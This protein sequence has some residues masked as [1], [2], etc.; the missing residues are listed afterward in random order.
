[1]GDADFIPVFQASGI[2][3]RRITW[4]SARRTRS[5][6]SCHRSDLQPLAGKNERPDIWS[7]L[8]TQ[9]TPEN[10][11]CHRS[12]SYPNSRRRAVTRSVAVEGGGVL[13]MNGARLCAK[14][15]PQQVGSAAARL[16]HSRAPKK[17]KPEHCGWGRV[18]APRG[19]VADSG[20]GVAQT[21]G[22]SPARRGI[23]PARGKHC[24][25]TGGTVPASAESL[26]VMW[27]SF[28]HTAG[29]IP[30]VCKTI[31]SGAGSFPRGAG[32][33]SPQWGINSR[34]V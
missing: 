14:R 6:P 21:A 31:P 30:V 7:G 29:M 4:A 16:R 27:G 8:F 1:M 2:C 12:S 33:D 15:Q 23:I 5:S 9:N 3:M 32:I 19:I 26:P 18:P 10:Q 25:A 13:A 34:C 20:C 11:A 17:C 22:A 24:P 28:P